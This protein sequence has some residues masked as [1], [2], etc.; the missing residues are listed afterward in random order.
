MIDELK[1]L[2]V[3]LARA[4]EDG[5]NLKIGIVVGQVLCKLQELIN[6]ETNRI[7]N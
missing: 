7:A 4:V 2:Y 6:E 1:S 3:S 5:D